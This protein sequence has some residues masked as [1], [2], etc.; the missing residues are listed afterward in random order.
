MKQSNDLFFTPHEWSIALV[1]AGMRR[2]NG[3]YNPKKL[4]QGFATLKRKSARRQ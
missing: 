1:I 3:K 4:Y 2:G